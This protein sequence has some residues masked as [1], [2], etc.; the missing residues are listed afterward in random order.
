MPHS[1]GL[2][3][4]GSCAL[5]GPANPQLR[6]RT[7]SSCHAGTGSPSNGLPYSA[8]TM[9]GVCGSHRCTWKNHRSARP[10]RSSQSSAWGSTSCACSSPML[11]I[12]F[13]A[14]MNPW[15]HQVAEWRKGKE[16]SEAVF[17]P[18]L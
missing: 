16:D 2:K 1:S 10:R 17:Q 4:H 9:Y 13:M 7:A 3:P 8:G 5:C 18:A 12:R 6:S 15:F 11:R 14:S